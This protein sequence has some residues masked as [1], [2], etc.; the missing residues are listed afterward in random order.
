MRF[1]EGAKTRRIESPPFG[2][3]G[4]RGVS[5]EAGN[6]QERS[7]CSSS[8]V[9]PGACREETM[10][11]DVRFVAVA[12]MVGCLGTATSVLHAQD[13]APTQKDLANPF[14]DRNLLQFKAPP[15]IQSPAPKRQ[16]P[17]PFRYSFPTLSASTRSQSAA[18]RQPSTICTMIVRRGDANVDPEILHPRDPANPLTRMP[19]VVPS[20]LPTPSNNAR[21]P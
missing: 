12:L 8:F 3:S 20:C 14:R 10:K 16:S 18:T 11:I 15:G 17:A 9:K 1:A 19:L 13:A 2:A 7:S 5:R 4:W 6:V 21:Q